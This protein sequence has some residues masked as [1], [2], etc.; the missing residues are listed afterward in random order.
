MGPMSRPR[1]L[2]AIGV[3]LVPGSGLLGCFSAGSGDG[4]LDQSLHVSPG[5][6][7]RIDLEF[8]SSV[9]F[10]RGSL[11]V[12]SHDRPG[13]VRVE[14]E[15]TGWG[16]YAV[17][18]SLTGTD[19]QVSLTGRVEG[20]LYW[21]FGGPT[22]DVRIWLPPDVRVEAKVDG[23]PVELQDLL[24]PVEIQV[25]ST[26]SVRIQRT[27]GPVQLLSRT[28]ALVAE[29]IVGPLSIETEH[30]AI[31]VTG[32]EG[33]VHV[34]SRHG[35]ISIENVTGSV[36]AENDRGRINVED[37]DGAVRAQ[38]NRGGI[39]LEEIDGPVQARTGRGSIKVEF[40]GAPSG[41]IETARGSIRVEYPDGAGFKLDAQTERGRL[42][43]EDRRWFGRDASISWPADPPDLPDV[44]W[45]FDHERNRED[46]Q[47][48]WEAWAENWQDQK[49]YWRRAGESL[50]DRVKALVNRSEFRGPINGGGPELR[51]R[52]RRGN[53]KL[54]SR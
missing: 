17:D 31:H 6:T 37:V 46:W 29:D 1:L 18:L 26:G 41:E 15:T 3:L 12:R 11:E 20:A 32:V 40:R 45:G 24:G 35:R 39:D 43:L 50:K 21:M 5:A 9:S 52:T 16:E 38:S 19:D 53:I 33:E 34:R 54:R 10:D 42:S 14:A 47:R 7:I 49:R 28:G 13:E 25:D 30:G 2:L 23:G 8:G 27:E 44:S 4:D 51:I 48:Q 36:I 22:I